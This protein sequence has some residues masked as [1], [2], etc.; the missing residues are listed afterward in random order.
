MIKLARTVY[1]CF[2]VI[3]IGVFRPRR[4]SDNAAAILLGQEPQNSET[5]EILTN[6]VAAFSDI[7]SGVEPPNISEPGQQPGRWRRDTPR[8]DAPP[9]AEK[10]SDTHTHTHT[11]MRKDGECCE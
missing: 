1:I 4:I 10:I 11:H 3:K 8:V 2:V 5:H 7:L 9:R 6:R